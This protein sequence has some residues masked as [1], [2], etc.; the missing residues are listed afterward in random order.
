MQMSL[1]VVQHQIHAHV[2]PYPR[3]DTCLDVLVL[4]SLTTAMMDTSHLG[5]NTEHASLLEDG[6]GL[7]HDVSSVSQYNRQ[8][9]KS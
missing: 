6:V 3:M 8:Q 5:M 1:F 2:P 9:L 4:V 7:L